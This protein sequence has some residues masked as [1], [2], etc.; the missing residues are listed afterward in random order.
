MLGRTLPVGCSPPVFWEGSAGWGDWGDGLL[1]KERG[2]TGPGSI[3]GEAKG[4]GA[5]D[6]LP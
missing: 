2:E 4:N 5:R 3:Q 6:K 1:D